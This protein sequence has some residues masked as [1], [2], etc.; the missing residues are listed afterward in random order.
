MYLY[1]TSRSIPEKELIRAECLAITG[2]APDKNGIALSEDR[3]DVSRAAYLRT[4]MGILSQANDLPELNNIL[5]DMNISAEDFRVSVEGVPKSLSADSLKIMQQVGLRIYGSPNLSNPKITFLVVI[6]EGRIWLGEVTSR[7]SNIYDKHAHKPH[8]YSSSLPTRL[9]RAMV[10]LVAK[11]GD[12]IIDPCCG[13]GT[14]LIESASA[15]ICSVGCDINPA[16]VRASIENLEYFGLEASISEADARS[17]NGSFDAVVTDLP[18]GRNCP[19]DDQL[20]QEILQNLRNL[21]P[22]AA[23]ALCLDE[24]DLITRMGYSIEKVIP[25]PKSSLTRYIYVIKSIG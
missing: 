5:D 10:N 25:V 2:A 9:A 18:Y 8:Q 19:S 6:T 16:M 3:A 11:P 7:S 14:I 15:G 20:C 4:G 13:S 12:T 22:I 17:I 1:L 24:I 23:V 21:A